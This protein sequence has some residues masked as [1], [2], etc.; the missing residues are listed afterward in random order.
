MNYVYILE[1]VD[2]TLYTGW[3]NDIEKRIKAHNDGTGSKYTRARLPVRLVYFEEYVSKQEAM[4]IEWHI[5]RLSRKQKL[6][7]IKEKG[8]K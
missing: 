5:K 4:S 3:T 2:G 1:C 6:E 8:V 7:L